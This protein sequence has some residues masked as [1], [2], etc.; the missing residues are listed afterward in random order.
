MTEDQLARMFDAD[1]W[2]A[3]IAIVA[4]TGAGFAISLWRSRDPV[5][6]TVLVAVGAGLAAVAMAVTGH[7]LG[8]GDPDAALAAAEAGARVPAQLSI[9]AKPAYLAWPISSLVGAL[10]VLWSTPKRTPSEPPAGAEA[11]EVRRVA[12]RGPVGTDV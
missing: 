1:G 3:V 7:L 12:G 6:T 4:G 10:L 9:S 2:Y 8:P 5:L 11:A